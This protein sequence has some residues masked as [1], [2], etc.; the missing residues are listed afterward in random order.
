MSDEIPVGFSMPRKARPAPALGCVG[1][2]AD[3]QIG[4]C[5]SHLHGSGA[6]RGDGRVPGMLVGDHVVELAQDRGGDGGLCLARKDPG[7]VAAAV[8]RV[9]TDGALRAQLVTAGRARVHD[10]DLASSQAKLRA[11]IESVV[12]GR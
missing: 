12:D 6:V 7:T 11:V 10:F 2:G 5:G 8:H 9:L 3:A 4:L 1:S